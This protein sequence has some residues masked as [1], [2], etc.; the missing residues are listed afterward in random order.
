MNFKRFLL[1]L[2]APLAMVMSS[3]EPDAP[4]YTTP[5]ISITDASGAAVTALNF[6]AEGGDQTITITATRGWSI[7][8]TSTWFA[9]SP[10]SATN[11]S[12]EE[13]T[14]EVKITA[15]PN[16]GEA[17]TETI[18]VVMDK[19]EKSIVVS[20]AG[21]G[22]VALGAQ[23]FGDN[24]D[25]GTA[26][27][28]SG[29]PALDGFVNPV[30]DAAEGVTYTVANVQA[31]SNSPS[32]NSHSG[33]KDEASGNNNAF[34]RTNGV[35][36]INNINLS[37]QTSKAYT[38]T[39]GCYRS[40]YED[41]DN[42]FKSSEFHV[43]L[44]A[45]GE[46]WTEVAY[47]RPA[48][49]VSN[50][51]TWNKATATFSLK[52]KPET[53]SIRFVS[54]LAS[55]HRLDDVKFFVGGG[56]AEVDLAN[57]TTSGGNTGGSEGGT[58][59]DPNAQTISVADFIAAADTATTYQ[60]TGV[61]SG[62]INTQYGNFDLV[63][64]SGS[65]YIYGLVDTTGAN[66][67]W[68]TKGL[69]AGDTIT[70]QGKY[71]LYTGKDGNTKH[72]IVDALYV[73]H[74]DGEGGEEPEQPDQPVVDGDFG[75]DAAFV[76]S[77]D[78][79]TNAAY[80]LGESKVNGASATGFKLGK[81]KQHG[82]FASQAIGVSGDKYLN[83]YAVSW[84]AGGDQTIYFRVNGG[85]VKSQAIKANAGANNNPPFTITVT[86][87]DHYSVLLSGLSATD[88]IEFSTNEAFDCK[89]TDPD[90]ATRAIFFGV[91]L[92]DEPLAG[93][94]G[95]ETPEPEDPENPEDPETPVIP[96]FPSGEEVTATITFDNTAKR[97]E[98]TTSVQVWQEN[99]ITV[100]NNKSASTT[101]IA[102]YSDP[103]R[104]YK[105]SEVVIA[106]PATITKLVIE[107]PADGSSENQKY[108]TF[109]QN[110]LNGTVS[111]DGTTVTVVPATV[112]NTYTFSATAGQ[113]RFYSVAVTYISNGSEG[114]ETPENPEG[115]EPTDPENPE[116]GEPTDPE[117][118]E[119]GEPT[120]PENPEGGEPTDPENPEGGE[121]PEEP[122]TPVEPETPAVTTL[123]VQE[124]LNA[125]E[126]ASVWYQLTGV[127]KNIVNTIYGNFDLVDETGSV[128]VYG[129][130]ATQVSSNDKS[131]STLGLVDGDTVTL[132]GVRAAHNGTAQVGGPA[133][134]VSHIVNTTPRIVGVSPTTISFVAD[135]GEKTVT[136]NTLGEGGVLAATTA[137][138]WLTVSAAD[139]VV[140]IVAA[141]NEGEARE[142]EVTVTFGEDTAT[143]AVAQFAK[144]AEGEAAVGGKA[145]F[146][147]EA[148]NTSYAGG[149]TD[150]GWVYANCA[151]LNGG[152]S[153]NNPTFK[154]FGAESVHA[155]CM[156]GKTTAVG[157]ITSPALATGCGVLSFNYGLPYGDNKI[158][159]QVEIKQG[160][161][162]VDS[163]VVEKSTAT[164]FEV[165][166]HEEVINVAGEFQIVFTNL[167]PSNST[168][169]KDRAAIWNVEW[170]GYTE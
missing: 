26:Q 151:V 55:S 163:F 7:S 106:A 41:A 143:V 148:T 24:F 42:S 3:C 99:G 56:G 93:N 79:S 141:A 90:Y 104:F 113:V 98:F 154:M 36:T 77:A 96:E 115:G 83:F 127:V 155:F 30:G 5:A 92:T 13:K 132:M 47:T 100:T 32:N 138:E 107:S 10:S 125:A 101:N 160:G 116:G 63:D 139:G 149:T 114:G 131:F 146:E 46:K 69:N 145:D 135:G 168:S 67:N 167:S 118:P 60:L 29:W 33:Y 88:T 50:Y 9:I 91:K 57:G 21:E 112:S 11:E 81:S 44:S 117:N 111:V 109:L 45:D 64:E 158:K 134:Y 102:D 23:I 161:E 52:E 164:K 80:T 70:V 28:N 66:V 17:R 123:T 53:L 78:N 157:K 165:Y 40:V 75:S 6:A 120:D 124:F 14:T 119:G 86:D 37:A 43:L 133:Y 152:N 35:L 94:E 12:M 34:F 62:S 103:V 58:E 2:V 74:V 16:D 51:G 54:D 76:C 18:K 82:K 27:D 108:L 156:N 84:G 49:E 19:T 122:E 85:E 166:A 169:N 65:I 105:N 38:L 22:Q 61:I 89:N 15:A 97:T 162:V 128:Y 137:A 147:T 129:L 20:Q 159:F 68:T 72:E 48:D 150:A 73:S 130:T 59:V 121:T 39:F 136:V 31:R 71:Y 95:G 144:P 8:K 153:D 170:T 25:N 4:V 87:A 110:S 126:D 142:A 140:T 1:F